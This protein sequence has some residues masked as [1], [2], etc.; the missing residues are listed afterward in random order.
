M[1]RKYDYFRAVITKTNIRII[2]TNGTKWLHAVLRMG[3]YKSYGKGMKNHQCLVGGLNHN[4]LTV[5]K[6]IT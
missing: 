4:N 5:L 3:A 1:I 6:K 2:L